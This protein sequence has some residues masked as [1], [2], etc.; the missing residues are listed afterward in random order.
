MPVRRGYCAL[1]GTCSC[2]RARSHANDSFPARGA[3]EW[4]WA[5]GQV[6]TAVVASGLELL[7]LGEYPE[8][9]WKPGNVRAAAWDGRLPNSFSLLARR[10]SNTSHP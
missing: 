6:V 7:S 2:T 10:T 1:A 4:Q 3:T 5:L 9:F 8:P